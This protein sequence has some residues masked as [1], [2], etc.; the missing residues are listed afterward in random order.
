MP[1]PIKADEPKR[2]DSFSIFIADNNKINVL[3]LKSQLES[4]CKNFTLANDGKT[5]LSYLQK[6]KYDLI[7]LDLQMPYFTEL[8]LIKFIKQPSSTNKDS[9]VIAIT[10]HIQ[11]QQRK[12]LIESGFDECL[13]K[14]VLLEQLFEILERWLPEENSRL[15]DQSTMIDYVGI[16]LDKTAGNN[17]LTHK[18]FSELFSELQTQSD[19]IEWALKKN[20]LSVA[21][22]TTHKLHG[23]VSFCGFTDLQVCAR[24]LEISLSKNDSQQINPDFLLLK[25][26]IIDFISLKESILN[27]LLES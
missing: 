12:T 6:N 17:E 21:E 20:E 3:L 8:E 4:H 7:L 11:S 13:V 9:P 25:N 2:S 14:P 5:A 23:S 1:K 15:N 22:E 27:Q 16:L 24:A 10:A 26:K 19:T 18:L